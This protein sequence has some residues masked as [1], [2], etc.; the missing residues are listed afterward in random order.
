MSEENEREDYERKYKE[1]AVEESCGFFV[2]LFLMI[3]PTAELP[4][5]KQAE[6]PFIKFLGINCPFLLVS[7]KKIKNKVTKRQQVGK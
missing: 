5:E 1:E 3:K 7:S 4:G 2:C 6:F